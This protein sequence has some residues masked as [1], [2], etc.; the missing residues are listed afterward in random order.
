MSFCTVFG[1]L[2]DNTMENCVPSYYAVALFLKKVIYYVGFKAMCFNKSYLFWLQNVFIYFIT[3]WM[4]I[5]MPP[6]Y[7]SY[8][9]LNKKY[10]SYPKCE[11]TLTESHG[12]QDRP[13][14]WAP[15]WI[16]SGF[17]LTIFHKSDSLITYTVIWHS[18][19]I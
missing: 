10:V 18:A 15:G 2:S 4:C 8:L 19:L 17:A 12:T 16:S 11:H 6:Y 7:M 3:D 13:N 9:P 5:H 1:M 14:G